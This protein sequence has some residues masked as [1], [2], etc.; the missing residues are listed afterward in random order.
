MPLPLTLKWVASRPNANAIPVRPAG[1]QPPTL[2]SRRPTYCSTSTTHGDSVGLGPL[3]TG[4]L[5]YDDL[6][7]L[8]RKKPWRTLGSGRYW[9]LGPDPRSRNRQ[10]FGHGAPPCG[11]NCPGRRG[12]PPLARRVA[13]TAKPGT[14]DCTRLLC[15]AEEPP[16]A[17]RPGDRRGDRRLVVAGIAVGQAACYRGGV[18]D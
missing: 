8:L 17:E 16:L 12:L 18:N 9:K 11:W 14:M 2:G 15:R 10:A 1:F 4:H 6:A 3:T 13:A 7:A 5:L